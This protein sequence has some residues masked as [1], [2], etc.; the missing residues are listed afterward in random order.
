MSW[1]LERLIKGSDIS[2]ECDAG[3][4]GSDGASPYPENVPN[5]SLSSRHS[6]LTTTSTLQPS[7][8]DAAIF[9]MIP[10]TSCLATIVLFLRDKIH[11]I[12]EAL[13]K[14]ALMG[15]KPWPNPYLYSVMLVLR[16]RCGIEAGC[17]TEEG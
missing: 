11:L 13:L 16:P 2:G 1:S 9:L 7:L 6:G 10:G 5:V 4:P 15:L 17:R 3:N 14:L 12:A 8:R